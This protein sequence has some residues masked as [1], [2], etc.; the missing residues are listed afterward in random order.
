[1]EEVGDKY[2]NLKRW[3]E[4]ESDK[5]EAKAGNQSENLLVTRQVNEPE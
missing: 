1:M 5:K 3:E 4:M 2:E